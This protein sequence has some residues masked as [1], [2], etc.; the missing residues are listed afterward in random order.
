MGTFDAILRSVIHSH[1]DLQRKMADANAAAIQLSLNPRNDDAAAQWRTSVDFLDSAVAHM[2]EEEDEIFDDARDAGVSSLLLQLLRIEHAR[3]RI[4][5]AE[6]LHREGPD[7]EGALL[8]LRFL[9]RFER[10]V[11]HEEWCLARRTT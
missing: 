10:H 3:L 1:D 2:A 11:G 7:D 6:I 9:H 5:A 8:L 4:L